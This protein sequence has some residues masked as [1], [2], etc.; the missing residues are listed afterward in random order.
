VSEHI[1]DRAVTDRATEPG[2]HVATLPNVIS[3][4]RLCA[5]PVAVWLA[6]R[7]ALQET[8]ALFLAAGASDALDGWLA[9]RGAA[10]QLGAILDPLADKALLI[11]MFVTLA[12]L[13]ILP[14]YLAVL[15]VARDV[16]IIGGALA[17][18]ALGFPL[19]LRPL[20]VSKLNTGLQV[21]LVATALCLAGF[22]LSAPLLLRTLVWAV[23]ASTLASGLAYGW[24]IGRHCG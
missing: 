3:V 16:L 1:S 20:M 17:L 23:V 6:L 10:S 18:V 9:R 12:G 19:V 5:V 14:Q 24:R 15:V 2:W 22:G 8:F 21:L 11:S 7:G 13:H 4:L